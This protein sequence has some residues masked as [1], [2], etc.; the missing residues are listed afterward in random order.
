MVNFK[1]II[2]VG[3][4]E[5]LINKNDQVYDVNPREVDGVNY[6]SMLYGRPSM[7]AIEEFI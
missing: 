5:L 3:D 2:K 4:L 7:L 6:F 1:R